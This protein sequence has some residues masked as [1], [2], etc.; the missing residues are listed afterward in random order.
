[1]TNFERTETQKTYDVN[2]HCDRLSRIVGD[3]DVYT[4]LFF[5]SGTVVTNDEEEITWENVAEWLHVAGSVHAVDIVTGSFDMSVLFCES[6]LDYE[7]ARS[8]VLSKLVANLSIFNFVWSGLETSLDLIEPPKVPKSL[9][10]GKSSKIDNAI[11]YLKNNFRFYD[12][13]YY[14]W[15]IAE[16]RDTIAK[17]PYYSNLSDQFKLQPYIGISGIGLHVVRKIRNK[18]A[19]G[20]MSIPEPEDWTG[21]EPLDAKLIELSARI[22]LLSIQMLIMAYLKD[23]DFLVRFMENDDLII[24]ERSVISLLRTIHVFSSNPHRDQLTLFDLN[25]L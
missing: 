23:D 21:I 3:Q 13:P 8:K 16:L 22:V 5:K 17:I 11:F 15:T 19:H 4:Q 2:E 18:L 20:T 1:M 12:L 9:K 7:A 14:D 6:V 24:T 10:P 25:G